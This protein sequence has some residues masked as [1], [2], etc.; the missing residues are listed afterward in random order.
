[1]VIDFYFSPF[2]V[3]LLVIPAKAGIQKN[4][5]EALFPRFIFKI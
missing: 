5:V 4:F 1:M 2:V 3:A